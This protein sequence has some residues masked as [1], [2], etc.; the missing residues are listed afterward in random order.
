LIYKNV[1]EIH[2]LQQFTPISRFFPCTFVKRQSDKTRD[3]GDENNILFVIEKSTGMFFLQGVG[4]RLVTKLS[5]D[6]YFCNFLSQFEKPNCRIKQK[7]TAVIDNP[8]KFI[9]NKHLFLGG[10][11]RRD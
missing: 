7:N 11:L 10:I 8:K 3:E 6:K 5:I 2:F 4:K 9:Y 1:I